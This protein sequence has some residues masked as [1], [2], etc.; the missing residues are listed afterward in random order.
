LVDRSKVVKDVTQKPD[1]TFCHCIYNSVQNDSPKLPLPDA[2]EV[3]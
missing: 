3:L 1:I 2:S